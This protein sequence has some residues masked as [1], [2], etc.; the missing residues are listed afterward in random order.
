M[1]ALKGKMKKTQSTTVANLGQTLNVVAWNGSLF[2][3]LLSL[4]KLQI[5]NIHPHCGQSYTFR[6]VAYL[7]SCD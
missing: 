4:L 2:V 7:L 1:I 3:Y 6:S 5:T